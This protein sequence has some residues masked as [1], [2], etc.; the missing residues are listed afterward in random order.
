MA[1]AGK[2]RHEYLVLIDAFLAAMDVQAAEEA[3]ATDAL[4]AD[5]D[6]TAGN[7]A[8]LRLVAFID[9]CFVGEVLY[10]V[11]ALGYA[12]TPAADLL[13]V[14]EDIA[15]IEAEWAA[16][17]LAQ[18]PSRRFTAEEAALEFADCGCVVVEH[19]LGAE[20]FAMKF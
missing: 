9:D 19:S 12:E 3:A 14:F 11:L 2:P 16:A 5:R 1:E 8:L 6:V 17:V 18:A 4:A 7:A 13:A 10:Q 20:V 15:M